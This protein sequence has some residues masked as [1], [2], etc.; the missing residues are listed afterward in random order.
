MTKQ[1]TA[2]AQSYFHGTRANLKSGDLIALGYASNYGRPNA[3]HVYLTSTLDAAVWGAEL[4]QGE[5]RERIYIVEPTGAIED[6]PELTD[7]RFPGN[8][9]MSYRTADALRVLGEVTDWAGHAPEQLKTMREHLGRL[10][11]DSAT[12]T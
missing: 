3:A 10:Q 6:D 11:Q 4:A 7:Q 12:T 1:A 8:R 2:F 5:G 9:T